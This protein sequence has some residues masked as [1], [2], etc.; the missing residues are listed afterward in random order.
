MYVISWKALTDILVF[1]I[2]YTLGKKWFVLRPDIEFLK[3]SKCSL[4][5]YLLHIVKRRKY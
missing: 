2:L 5:N 3:M 1:V 4:F